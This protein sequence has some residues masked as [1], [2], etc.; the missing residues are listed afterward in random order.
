MKAIV[1]L[2]MDR[3]NEEFNAATGRGSVMVAARVS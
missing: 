2:E 3:F 1:P